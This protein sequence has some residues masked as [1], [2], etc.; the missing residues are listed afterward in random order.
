MSTVKRCGHGCPSRPPMQQSRSH[1]NAE[2]KAR[3]YW[4]LACA[5]NAAQHCSPSIGRMWR[6]MRELGAPTSAL[7]RFWARRRAMRLMIDGVADAGA[8]RRTEC[9]DPGDRFD[10][11]PEVE[12]GE[13]RSFGSSQAG[14]GA[15]A[16][17]VAVEAE[18]S[19]GGVCVRT[20]CLCV[21]G[22]V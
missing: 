21:C 5:T 6:A 14:L 18:G 1:S 12:V 16:E 20:T 15:F 17:L 7:H 10:R 19:M 8:W 13:L 22:C 11:H 9:S 3:W 4:L 2:M